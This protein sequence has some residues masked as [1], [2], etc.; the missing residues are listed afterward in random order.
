MD[1]FDK[2]D[3]SLIKTKSK[4]ITKK[5]SYSLFIKNNTM[6][7]SIDLFFGGIKKGCISIYI[8]NIRDNT[9]ILDSLKYDSKCNLEQ[10]LESG[11]GTKHML[12]TAFSY[13]KK[14]YPLVEYA[15]LIDASKKDCKTTLPNGTTPSIN[16]GL[17]HLLLK[18]KTWYESILGATIENEQIRSE[19]ENF[20]SQLETIPIKNNFN[21]FVN[22]YFR[23]DVGFL[24]YINNKYNLE[25]DK[26]F[27]ESKYYFVFFKTLK[28]K[29][30]DEVD[31]CLFFSIFVYR[32][33]N[34]I[35]NKR[36]ITFM[37]EYWV[38]PIKNLENIEF[39]EE[40]YDIKLGGSFEKYEYEF[41]GGYKPNLTSIKLV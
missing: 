35:S 37:S 32:F 41:T 36:I 25:I 11:S 8:D 4:L 15:K 7:N 9:V 27:N 14:K 24:K 34:D 17:T 1:F 20:T 21:K 22:D 10:D 40:E 19:Y 26:L 3:K 29:I 16:L 28:E 12:N 18:K 5:G 38:F 30:T 2:L 31:S 23:N 6:T 39:T 13:I 33:M